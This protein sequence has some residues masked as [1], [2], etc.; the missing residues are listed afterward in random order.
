MLSIEPL[1]NRIPPELMKLFEAVGE[2]RELRK[3][4]VIYEEGFPCPLVPLILSGSVRVFKMGETG[5]EITLYRVE[6][7]ELC[8]LSSTCALAAQS[9]K[10][11]ALAMAESDVEMLAIPVHVFRKML[12][13]RPQIHALLNQMLTGRLAE[14]M[15][16]VDEVAFGRLDLR[17]AERM[18]RGT[19]GDQ[20]DSLQCT[21]QELAM[22]LGS[23][24]EVI[25]RVLKDYERRGVI[26]LGRGRIT[27]VDRDGL[28]T[29]AE[30]RAGG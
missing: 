20:G 21:H 15:M 27:V 6:A 10:L 16:V 9:A 14:M 11:P 26:K 8:V 13:E 18:L 12:E 30:E 24:R 5:R 2:R 4:A 17:L 25:S 3:G 28:Q 7:G 29:L 22:E 23:A 1:D 19:G